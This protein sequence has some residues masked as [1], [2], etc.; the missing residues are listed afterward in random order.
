MQEG[1]EGRIFYIRYEAEDLLG[2]FA[3]M[4]AYELPTIFPVEISE[5]EQRLGFQTMTLDLSGL[6]PR[7]GTATEVRLVA[8]K[9]S[10]SD[11]LLKMLW[12]GAV[13]YRHIRFGYRPLMGF[14]P[15]WA[16]TEWQAVSEQLYDAPDADLQSSTSS[17]IVPVRF[18]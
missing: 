13:R 5:P 18:Q 11:L 8:K 4:S 17:K 6:L 12:Q 2:C 10:D 3:T 1:E 15:P 9:I 14:R 16:R 7:S